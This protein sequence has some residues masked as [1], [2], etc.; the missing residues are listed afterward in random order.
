MGFYRKRVQYLSVSVCAFVVVGPTEARYFGRPDSSED[1]VDNP[2]LRV[3]GNRAPASDGKLVTTKTFFSRVR[4]VSSPEL[5][6][7]WEDM[8]TISVECRHLS[9]YREVGHDSGCVNIRV[10]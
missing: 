10:N 2:L 4:R 1:D 8:S 9:K 7:C 3:T 6:L 5:F